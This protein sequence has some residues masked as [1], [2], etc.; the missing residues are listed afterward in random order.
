M[1]QVY[2]SDQSR[3]IFGKIKEEKLKNKITQALRKLSQDPY[4]DKKL[5]GIL[6]GTY[7]IKVWPYR[8]LYEF[9]EK[10]DLII[11]DIGNRKDIYR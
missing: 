3:K 8:I 1:S 7:S 10:K 9:T 6:E 2:F 4:L 5:Q 11:T